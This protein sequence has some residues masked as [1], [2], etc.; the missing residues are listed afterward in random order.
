MRTML[1]PTSEEAGLIDMADEA[2]EEEAWVVPE[3]AGETARERPGRVSRAAGDGPSSSSSTPRSSSSGEETRRR[4]VEEARLL[5]ASEPPLCKD[6]PVS[7]V[8]AT[9]NGGE[10]P[11]GVVA[12][13]R[14]RSPAGGLMMPGKY[15]Y[16]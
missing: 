5:P 4:S 14:I 9:L 11:P 8:V 7:A 13:G 6:P 15:L 2:E 3:P 12:A 1:L 16:K 10:S